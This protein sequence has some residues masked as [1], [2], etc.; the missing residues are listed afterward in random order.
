MNKPPLANETMEQTP[1]TAEG[2]RAIARRPIDSLCLNSMEFHYGSALQR[3]LS[4]RCMENASGETVNRGPPPSRRHNI[5]FLFHLPPPI[6]LLFPFIA[7]YF[8]GTRVSFPYRFICQRK[9]W[10]ES[11]NESLTDVPDASC[12][13]FC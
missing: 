9:E 2:R 8:L 5:G 10:L 4:H 12:S 13:T 7:N 11:L 1:P 3:A 6:R